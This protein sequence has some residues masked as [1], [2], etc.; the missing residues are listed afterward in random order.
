MENSRA[1]GTGAGMGDRGPAERAAADVG[2]ATGS[3]AGMGSEHGSHGGQASAGDATLP[4]GR[5][6]ELRR[7]G[8]RAV[9]TEVGATL[10]VLEVGEL[11]VLQGFPADGIPDAS[12]GQVLIPFPNRIDR[13]RY[14]FHGRSLELPLDEPDRSNA[15]HGL[16]RWLNWAPLSHTP[17]RLVMGL[18]LHARHGYPFVLSLRVAYT[19]TP[20]GLRVRQSA[21]NLGAEPAPYGAGFHPY[22]T[23]GTRRIDDCLLKLPARTSFVVNAQLIPTGRASVAATPFDFRKPRVIGGTVMDTGFADLDRDPDGLARVELAAPGGSPRLSVLLDGGYQFLQV[24]TGDGLPDESRRRAIAIEPYTCAPNAFN[25]GLGLRVLAPG[26][27]FSSV[28][29]IAAAT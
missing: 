28:W 23:V 10:R 27:C 20:C 2:L 19:L 12:R 15:M 6:F 4:T 14:A 29:K 13:G 17:S 8:V 11:S 22:L 5:Q 26:Q 18:V 9:V 7:G 21:R 24:F 3:G 16:V 25:N 1:E